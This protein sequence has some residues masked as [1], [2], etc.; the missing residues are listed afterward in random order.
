MKDKWKKI[1]C[2]EKLKV[3]EI[4]QEIDAIKKTAIADELLTEVTKCINNLKSNSNNILK[5]NY[6]TPEEQKDLVDLNK[7]VEKFYLTLVKNFIKLERT[8]LPYSI[9]ITKLCVTEGANGFDIISWNVVFD[10]KEVV[11]LVDINK[12][13]ADILYSLYF[14]SNH[15]KSNHHY[16]LFLPECKIIEDKESFEELMEKFFEVFMNNIVTS[17]I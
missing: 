1:L 10:H 8:L 3:E 9:E 14:S 7:K 6:F 16:E 17:T 4:Y 13:D 2:E 5:N 11:F 12:W 15:P